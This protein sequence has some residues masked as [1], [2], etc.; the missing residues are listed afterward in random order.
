MKVGIIGAK[1]IGR[2]HVR[3]FL[4]LGAEVAV[5]CS[6]EDSAREY[7]KVHP[8]IPAHGTVDELL[9]QGLDAVSICSPNHM[10]YSHAKS[11]LKKGLHVLCEKPLNWDSQKTPE[12]NLMQSFELFDIAKSKD[13]ILTV[14]TQLV[15]LVLSYTGLYLQVTGPDGDLEYKSF[16]YKHYISRQEEGV[17]TLVDI[18]PHALAMLLAFYNDAKI[19]EI[20]G[21]YDKNRWHLSLTVSSQ[22]EVIPAVLELGISSEKLLEFGIDDMIAARLTETDYHKPGY[23]KSF[24]KLGEKSIEVDDPLAVS[25]KCFSTAVQ[26]HKKPDSLSNLIVSPE[27]AFSNAKLMYGIIDW[28]Y[29]SPIHD[30]LRL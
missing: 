17:E 30:K 9:A 1:G 27:M 6:S 10:H 16:N 20:S 24:L 21:D 15:S 22:H 12:E 5:A 3:E 28:V 13:A 14:N 19:L 26:E 2:Y 23:L 4:D 25:I 11:A 7:R 29:F 18:L 8:K